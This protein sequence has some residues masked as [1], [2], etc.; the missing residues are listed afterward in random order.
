[1]NTKIESILESF[2]GENGVSIL[3]NLTKTHVKYKKFIREQ[4]QFIGD[5]ISKLVIHIVIT[6]QHTFISDDISNF[7]HWIK[8]NPRVY[9]DDLYKNHI[10]IKFKSVI[11][12]GYDIQNV[13]DILN[14][15]T[16]LYSRKDFIK[17]YHI[18]LCIC[19]K[20]KKIIPSIIK[21]RECLCFEKIGK[22]FLLDLNLL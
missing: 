4:I 1:M 7:Y 19:N 20:C 17:P 13:I 21:E 14:S 10:F 9:K 12:R 16:T 5:Y 2:N 3:Q 11:H 6:T 22:Y 15:I 8:C 18:A